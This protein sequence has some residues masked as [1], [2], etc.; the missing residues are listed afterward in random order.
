[1]F[2]AVHR[3]LRETGSFKPRTHVGRGRRNVQDD[4]VLLDA[5]NDNP[6]SSTR[7]IASQTGLSQSAVWRVLRESSLHP[8]Y[9]QPV[10]V[11]QPGDKERRLEYCRWLLHRVVDEPDF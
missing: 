11:L 7:R 9:L 6:S 4:E 5:V 1:V 3:R 10:Q 2:E 8:F